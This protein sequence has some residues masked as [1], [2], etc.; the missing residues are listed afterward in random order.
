MKNLIDGIIN[1]ANKGNF[2][3][4]ISI[5]KHDKEIIHKS[6]GY[7][8]SSEKLPNEKNTKFGI[9]SGTKLFTA[10]GIGKLIEANKL[11]FDTKIMDID[12]EYCT[13]INEEATIKNILTHTSGIYDYYD[14]EINTDSDDFFVEIPWNQLEN[15]TDYLPLF[16]DEKPK[17][18]PN[19]RFSYS[20]GGYVFLGI[21][22]EK[23]T[24]KKYR[25]FIQEQIL[26]PIKMGNSGFFALNDLPQ[27]TANGYKEDRQTTNIFNL[28]IRG[29]GDGGMF[30][31]ADDMNLFWKDFFSFNILPKELTEIFIDTHYKFNEKS[32]YGCGIYKELD[33]SMYSIVGGDAGVGFDSRYLLTKDIVINI[34]SNITDGEEEM[35]N[36]ILSIIDDI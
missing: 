4:V 32:G 8:N 23:I 27:N 26:R 29:G 1:E 30:T 25:D 17:F 14:E 31:N 12:K 11:N 15:P 18:E 20:N 6:F 13:F 35:R 7:R 33:N 2:S 9:A 28:P 21:L 36:Y 16:I 5:Y 19:K 10:L 3:G 24:G 22:I 34:F